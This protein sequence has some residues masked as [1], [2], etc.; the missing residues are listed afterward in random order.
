MKYN[1][2]FLLT[3]SLQIQFAQDQ[4]ATDHAMQ[5]AYHA[6]LLP[7]CDYEWRPTVTGNRPP[8]PLLRMKSNYEQ[9]PTTTHQPSNREQRP[10]HPPWC[11]PQKFLT[12]NANIV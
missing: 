4:N 3:V 6:R 8:P 1:F 10:P 5:I 2:L 7:Y 11:V 9:C 12:T